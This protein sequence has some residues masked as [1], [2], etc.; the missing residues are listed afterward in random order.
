MGIPLVYVNREKFAKDFEN[1]SKLFNAPQQEAPP[2]AEQENLS[3]RVR[4]LRELFGQAKDTKDTDKKDTETKNNQALEQALA[5]K[6]AEQLRFKGLAVDEAKIQQTVKAVLKQYPTKEAHQALGNALYEHD[7]KFRNLV[8]ELAYGKPG[9]K[10]V[11]FAVPIGI[12]G[13]IAGLWLIT[14]CTQY[15]VKNKI[16][17]QNNP[18]NNGYQPYEDEG[19]ENTGFQ[20]HR[21]D[22]K[23]KEGY[24]VHE[25]DRDNNYVNPNAHEGKANSNTTTKAGEKVAGNPL[26]RDV[27]SDK[28]FFDTLHIYN[29]VKHLQTGKYKDLNKEAD[30]YDGMHH[31][32][33]PSAAAVIRAK[34]RELGIT[35]PMKIKREIIKNTNAIVITEELHQASRTWGGKNSKAQIE[36]DSYDLAKAA[37]RDAAVFK[38]NA[39]QLGIEA[40][41]IDDAIQ[42]MHV[43][44]KKDGLYN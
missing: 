39:M 22:N 2:A 41:L 21:D 15:Y 35:L 24:Q 44:N 3:D 40:Q 17:N 18:E 9:V 36:I 11:F 23:R 29:A 5:D 42:K 12:N 8:D 28:S 25:G 31:D 19:Q 7:E 32:H 4:K 26:G 27:E 20:A 16:I 33:W 13:L 38:R 10:P 37:A 43:L 34:E 30:A 1:I 6:I 14:T